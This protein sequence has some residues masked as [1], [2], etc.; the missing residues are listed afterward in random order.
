MEYGESGTIH[1][2]NVYRPP[3]VGVGN[4][5]ADIEQAIEQEDLAI[6][7]KG[8]HPEHLLSG[9]F[10]IHHEQWGRSQRANSNNRVTEAFLQLLDKRRLHQLTKRGTTTF[11]R[12]GYEA[13]LDPT[14][15]TSDV[16]TRM[17]KCRV[18]KE[19]DHHSDHLPVETI[20][21]LKAPAAA[22]EPR[23]MW[24]KVNKAKL[25]ATITP[26]P[27]SLEEQYRGG[28]T[29]KC[30]VAGYRRRSPMVKAIPL[31]QVRLQSPS[32]LTYLLNNTR[33]AAQRKIDLAIP[34]SAAPEG[35][36]AYRSRVEELVQE[37]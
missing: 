5:V 33:A 8:R 31:L 36:D 11:R 34:R 19:L 22:P 9:D 25:Q 26:G 29:S 16:S 1:I 24:K 18:A 35:E 2:Y 15:G 27:Q 3:A 13:T 28:L 30:R 12:D 7:A 4:W 21:N 37:V 23:K 10:N 32:D 17:V 20:L 6:R 14:F